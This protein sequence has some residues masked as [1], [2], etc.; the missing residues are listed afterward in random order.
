MHIEDLAHA[1]ALRFTALAGL[2][3]RNPAAAS[4]GAAKSGFLAI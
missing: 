3:R 2:L 4:P 1:Q